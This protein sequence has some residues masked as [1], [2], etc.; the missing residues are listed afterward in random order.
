MAHATVK[1]EAARLQRELIASFDAI[2]LDKASVG[3]C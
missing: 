3:V 2:G 1:I